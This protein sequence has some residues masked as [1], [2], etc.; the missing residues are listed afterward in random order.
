MTDQ[1]TPRRPGGRTARVRTDVHRA[2]E[3]LARAHPLSE[4]TLAQVA[5]RSG[6]HLGTLYRRWKTLDGLLLDVVNERLS[7]P[8][9]DTGS[10]REDLER[11]AR[12]AA[13]D[14]AGPVGTMLVQTLVAIRREDDGGG[15][16]KL[17]PALARRF[18]DLEAVLD[19]A[20]AR[21][22]DVPSVQEVFEVVLAPLYAAVLFGI[23]PSGPAAAGPLVERLTR[24][25]GT[26]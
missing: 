11:Y 15:L 13:D 6:V 4:L 7:A 25:V 9:P 22:E 10:L 8:M 17:P 23:G 19:R 24:L 12:R 21:G 18:D 2:V 20:A 26:A 5:D 3:E 16:D 1:P 14:L